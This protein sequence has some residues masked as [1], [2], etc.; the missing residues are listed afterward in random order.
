MQRATHESGGALLEVR[1]PAQRGTDE[2]LARVSHPGDTGGHREFVLDAT[3]HQTTTGN[4]SSSTGT[5]I[6][7]CPQ[8]SFEIDCSHPRNT[9]GQ[10]NGQI[11][12]HEREQHTELGKCTPLLCNGKEQA[13]AEPRREVTA[14]A[15]L[16]THHGGTTYVRITKRSGRGGR[17]LQ[18]ETS[19]ERLAR[20]ALSNNMGP[21]RHKCATET[22][23]Y[24]QSC[25][26][27]PDG[28]TRD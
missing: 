15:N 5:S 28:G 21:H 23:T 9:G 22:I 24:A 6:K 18:G 2:Q 11:D 14:K 1:S 4:T 3:G 26:L 16:C 20:P 27:A 13:T 8:L 25:D 17:F 19:P 10:R 12:N 7:T